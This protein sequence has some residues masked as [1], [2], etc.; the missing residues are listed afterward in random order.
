M[1]QRPVPFPIV[2]TGWR[3]D[4]LHRLGRVVARRGGRIA[5]VAARHGHGTAIGI[6]QHLLRIE[7][8]APGRVDRS[9]DAIPVEL[10]WQNLRD[11]S[12]PIVVGSVPLPIKREDM[13]GPRSIDRI[14]EEQLHFRGAFRVHREIHA[15]T[16]Y[17]GAKRKAAAGRNVFDHFHRI[18]SVNHRPSTQS[19]WWS[20]QFETD[21]TPRACRTG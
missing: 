18:R 13:R 4:A 11:K 5:I 3:D 7:P 2:S 16:D 12:V 21:T 19:W 6:Q 17:G 10:P 9:V 15:I 14:K 20:L 8:E 1:P